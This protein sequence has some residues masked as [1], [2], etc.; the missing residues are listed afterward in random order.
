MGWCIVG[1]FLLVAFVRLN[2]QAR[3]IKVLQKLMVEVVP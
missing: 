1:F 2:S 3:K